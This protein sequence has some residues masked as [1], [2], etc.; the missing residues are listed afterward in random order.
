MK[1]LLVWAAILAVIASVGC[2]GGGEPQ[3]DSLT[4]GRSALFGMASGDQ[5]AT[6]SGLSSALSLLERA[7]AA[8]PDSSE[9]RWWTA[10]CLVGM[11]GMDI[12]GETTVPPM[13]DDPTTVD[14]GSS[15]SGSS[16]GWVVPD[17]GDR[18]IPAAPPDHDGPVPPVEPPQRIGLVWNL[19]HAISNPYTYLTLLGPVADI[20]LGLVSVM[21]YPGDDA[22][23]RIATLARL[24]EA[25]RLLTQ[26]EADAGFSTTLPDP[27]ADGATIKIGLPEVHLLHAYAHVLRAEVALSLA[28]VRDIGP[29]TLTAFAES[30]PDG[31]G[32]WD[33]FRMLDSNGDK[34]LTP[35]EYL[36]GDPFLTLRDAAYMQTAQSAIL[37]SVRQAE[38]GCA[39]V[40]ARTET[41]G[42]LINNASPYREALA[43]MRDTALPLLRQAATGPV[44]FQTPHYEVEPID[45]TDP[46]GPAPCAGDGRMTF[47]L[48]PDPG[49]CYG[50]GTTRIVMRTIRINVAAWFASPPPDLKALA[51][52]LGLAS[53]GWLDP[54]KVSF[55]DLTFAGLFP[56]GIEPRDFFYGPMIPMPM[57]MYAMKR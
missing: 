21:G 26:V 54:E 55:P 57:P 22:Q 40:L 27:D 35:N 3:G 46:V 15:G 7:M 48:D 4:M 30:R 50:W 33:P 5:P 32:L 19:R 13:P 9:A 36:P 39:G 31:D 14:W 56:D 28:Y 51:P 10:V 47:E 41:D 43:E 29:L 34:Q 16:E 53:D 2:G 38:A 42:Y 11:V 25:D 49:D 18:D 17:P 20:R 52:T 44:E 24:D 45:G 1:T 12:G 37:S 6:R 8:Q 23:A